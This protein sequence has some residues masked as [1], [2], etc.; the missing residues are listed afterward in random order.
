MESK[1]ITPHVHTCTYTISYPCSYPLGLFR[2]GMRDLLDGQTNGIPSCGGRK[3]NSSS[4][5][6]ERKLEMK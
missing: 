5:E 1:T 2:R 6:M 4:W 3:Q